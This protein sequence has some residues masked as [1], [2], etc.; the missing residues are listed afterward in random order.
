VIAGEDEVGQRL[1]RPGFHEFGRLRQAHRA[2]LRNHFAHL[3]LGRAAILLGVNR[4]EHARHVGDLALRHVGE[5]VPVE[6]DDGTVEKP[7]SN[8][9]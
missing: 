1:V 7:L 4:F 8:Q 2:Q 5:Y 3:V 9:R 6:M